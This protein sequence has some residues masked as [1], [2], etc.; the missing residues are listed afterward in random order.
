M[1]A[2]A[3]VCTLF[4]KPKAGINYLSV[5]EAQTEMPKFCFCMKIIIEIIGSIVCVNVYYLKC[6]H[7]ICTH[8]YI[9]TCLLYKNVQKK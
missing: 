3:T 9:H 6:L 1:C 2:C 4:R 8:I 7:T 5:W